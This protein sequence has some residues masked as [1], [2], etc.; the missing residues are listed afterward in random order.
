MWQRVCMC[1]RRFDP[2]QEDDCAELDVDQ[3]GQLVQFTGVE[4]VN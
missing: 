3:V 1:T 4:I 2:S